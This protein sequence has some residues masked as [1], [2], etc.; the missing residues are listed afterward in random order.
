[1]ATPPSFGYFTKHSTRS[2]SYETINRDLCQQS[3]TSSLKDLKKPCPFF[4]SG[5][6]DDPAVFKSGDTSIYSSTNTL[7]VA[8]IINYATKQDQGVLMKQK[9]FDALGMQ[10]TFYH[11]H[12]EVI[13][14]AQGYFDLYNNHTVVNISNI[15]NENGFDFTGVYSNVFDTY[16]FLEEL[17]IK[18]TFLKPTSLALMQRYGKADGSNRY[19]YGIMKRF[20]E[21]GADAGIGHAGRT[22]GYTANMFYFPARNVSHVFVLNYGTDGDS[23]LKLVFLD[24]QNELVD[25]SFK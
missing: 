23:F 4:F 3:L 7:L 2:L 12:Q 16:K 21:R 17:L 6:Y 11:L 25:L 13:N 19:G 9:I 5:L 22:L 10:H 8:M 20:I 1:M 15:L 14:S 24:F 18:E